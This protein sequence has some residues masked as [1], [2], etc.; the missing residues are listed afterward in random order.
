MDGPPGQFR[1][2][3]MVE[4]GAYRRIDKPV[5]VP[6][7]FAA[8]LAEAGVSGA[9][10]DPTSVQVIAEDGQGGTGAGRLGVGGA[11][12]IPCQLDLDP[13]DRSTGTVTWL[14]AGETPAWTRRRFT[15]VFGTRPQLG[16]A[17]AGV[18]AS[19]RLR[20]WEPDAE[21]WRI[22][23]PPYGYYTFEKGGGAFNVFSPVDV[24]DDG[25]GDWVRF[26]LSHY[27]G[28]ANVHAPDFKTIFHQWYPGLV[29]SDG[30]WKVRSELVAAGPLKVTIRTTHVV[31]QGTAAGHWELRYEILPSTVR[32]TM[33]RGGPGGFA[34]IHEAAPGGRALDPQHAFVRLSVDEAPRRLSDVRFN[35]PVGHGWAYQG[36]DRVP[37]K[38]Y[39]AEMQDDGVLDAVLPFPQFH[40]WVVGWG[41]GAKAGTLSRG[42]TTYPATFYQGF[43][44]DGVTGGVDHEAVVAFIESIRQ[45]LS[46]TTGRATPIG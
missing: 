43:V 30:A 24:A 6:I 8:S 42:I 1:L 25:D 37:H 5:E 38:L 31:D 11:V 32:A 40:F 35:A 9:R 34:F 7:D 2:P 15:I 41:R 12:S 27:Q 20:L 19:H 46:V 3:V 14:L 26:D 28:I 21:H 23:A 18:A 45:P 39:L 17:G 13:D 29:S 16:S 44:D 10:I 33:V 4:T 36:D 22:E